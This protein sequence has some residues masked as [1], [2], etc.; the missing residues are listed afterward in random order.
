[1]RVDASR[2]RPFSALWHHGGDTNAEG[3]IDAVGAHTAVIGVGADNDYGHPHPN[4]LA[5]LAGTMIL[6]TDTG[7]SVSVAVE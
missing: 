2:V 1:M 7:G 5:D 4:V 3:F 6:R